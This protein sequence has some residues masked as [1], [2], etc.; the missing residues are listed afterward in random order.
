MAASAPEL[1]RS[2]RAIRRSYA[3]CRFGQLHYRIARAE[4]ASRPPIIVCHQTPTSGRCYEGLIAELGRDRIAVA[5]DTPGFGS[6]DPPPYAPSIQDYG[7]VVGDLADALGFSRFDVFG[8]HTGAKIAVE[9]ALQWPEA[10]RRVVLNAA[11]VYSDEELE[12][13][14]RQDEAVERFDEDGAHILARWRWA[15]R[16]RA[17]ETPLEAVALEV[18]ES[19]RAG[20]NVWHGHHAAFGYQHRENL[21]RVVQPVLVLHARDDLWAPTARARPLIRRGRMVDLPAY[22]REMI[23][24][25]YREVA[26]IVRAFLDAEEA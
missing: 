20:A 7:G 23:L 25:R 21:P 19:L 5:M 22:G 10:V 2:P 15:M 24:L 3:P 16:Q 13:L 11:P 6:S 9:A 4:V 14:K 18:A 1:W 8:D 17:P 26:E 12:A